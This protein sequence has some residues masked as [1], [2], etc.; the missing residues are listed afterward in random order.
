MYLRSTDDTLLKNRCALFARR[1]VSARFDADR[2][3]PLR[4]YLALAW[5]CGVDAHAFSNLGLADEAAFAARRT[6]LAPDYV[7][8]WL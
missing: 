2:G 6:R 5:Q 1:H 4:A 8:T 7:V 3:R